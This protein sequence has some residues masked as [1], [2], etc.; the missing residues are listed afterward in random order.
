MPWHFCWQVWNFPRSLSVGGPLCGHSCSGHVCWCLRCVFLPDVSFSDS[1]SFLLEPKCH[2]WLTAI[3]VEMSDSTLFYILSPIL[4]GPT[5]FYWGPALHTWVF[6][7]IRNWTGNLLLCRKMPNHLSHIS[8]GGNLGFN[9]ACR[10]LWC[11]LMCGNLCYRPEALGASVCVCLCCGRW[12][13]G[14]AW[15]RRHH[16]KGERSQ[17]THLRSDRPL[18]GSRWGSSRLPVAHTLH[19]RNQVVPGETSIHQRSAKHRSESFIYF[20]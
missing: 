11:T 19:A 4:T 15:G 16:E 13:E 18:S 10:W 9:K 8:Q 6:A 1:G 14:A 5:P 2:G 12:R 3:L 20:T 17:S 7:L